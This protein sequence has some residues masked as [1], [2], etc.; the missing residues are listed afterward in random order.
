VQDPNCQNLRQIRAY[1]KQKSV[2][3]RSNLSRSTC[4]CLGM[5]ACPPDFTFSMRK[6]TFSGIPGFTP[7]HPVSAQLRLVQPRFLIIGTYTVSGVDMC[8]MKAVVGC[9]KLLLRF[10][11]GLN[12]VLVTWLYTIDQ[13]LEFQLYFGL[14]NQSTCEM[15]T[16]R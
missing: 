12:R 5:F 13:H 11:P 15:R 7:L 4:T 2:S 8:V 14:L 6:L 10:T 16:F 3:L 9:R 1:T